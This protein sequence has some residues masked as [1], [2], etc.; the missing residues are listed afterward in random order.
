MIFF[1]FAFLT[2][3]YLYTFILISTSFYVELYYTFVYICTA[4]EINFQLSG[5]YILFII[6]IVLTAVVIVTW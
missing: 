4:T 1:V 6:I 5:C 3:L 2:T